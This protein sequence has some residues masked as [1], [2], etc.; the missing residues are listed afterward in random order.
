MV[1]LRCVRS[2]DSCGGESSRRKRRGVTMH[3]TKNTRLKRHKIILT[4]VPLQK[5][6]SQALLHRPSRTRQAQV[7]DWTLVTGQEGSGKTTLL[8]VLKGL[9]PAEG[10][11]RGELGL[12]V[13]IVDVCRTVQGVSGSVSDCLLGCT[14]YFQDFMGL[15]DVHRSSGTG[16]LCT[17]A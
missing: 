13:G 15:Y 8:R 3:R 2:T 9:W 16:T 5:R 14:R 4:T 12:G 7:K 11:V 17:S 6:S 1:L 10:V